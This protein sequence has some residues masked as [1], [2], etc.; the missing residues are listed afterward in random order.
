MAHESAVFCSFDSQQFIFFSSLW[1]CTESDSDFAWLP[2]QTFYVS[3]STCCSL[4]VATWIEH[5]SCRFCVTN[6]FHASRVLSPSP[7]RR[8]PNPGDACSVPKQ[9]SLANAKVNVRQHCV[10]LSCLCNSLTNW[11]DG[12]A[13]VASQTCEITRNSER[14]WP[15]SSSRSSKVIDL[16]FNRKPI[17]D[18]LLVINSDFSRI[19]Y[20]FRDIDA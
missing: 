12:S 15:Y 20:R 2:L 14:I 17:C 18:F 4:V 6:Y 16:G 1:N 13:V 5:I 7:P 9:E 3:D 19:W 11:M 10:S 8:A